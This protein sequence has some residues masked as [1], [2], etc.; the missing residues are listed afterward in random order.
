MLRLLAKCSCF[1]SVPIFGSIKCSGFWQNVAFLFLAECPNFCFLANAPFFKNS[2]ILKICKKCKKRMTLFFKKN[3]LGNRS[4]CKVFERLYWGFDGYIR[5][6]YIKTLDLTPCLKIWEYIYLF[7]LKNDLTLNC[8]IFCV[9][10]RGLFL[11]S[12]TILETAHRPGILWRFREGGSP[13]KAIFMSVFWAFYKDKKFSDL[14]GAEVALFPLPL[15]PPLGQLGSRKRAAH[16]NPLHLQVKGDRQN[17][18][19][20]GGGRL[21]GFGLWGG[22]APRLWRSGRWDI[23]MDAEVVGVMGGTWMVECWGDDV[24]EQLCAG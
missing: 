4:R 5:R 24:P 20:R 12:W 8:Y 2:K 15:A 9:I 14:E 18:I 23:M 22:R 19:T 17:F 13:K 10:I 21:S 16:T 11:P 3:Y 7:W 1:S 6:P